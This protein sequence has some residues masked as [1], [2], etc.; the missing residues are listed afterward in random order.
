MGL[1]DDAEDLAAEATRKSGLDDRPIANPCVLAV[2]YL[3]LRLI[4]RRRG[5]PRL[6]PGRII[7][8]ADATEKARAFFVAHEAFHELIRR[9]RWRCSKDEEEIAASRGGCALQ[10]PRAP[11]LR[12]VRKEGVDL[13]RLCSLWTLTT[14]WVVARRI[15]ELQP[16]LAVR[17]RRGRGLDSVGHGDPRQLRLAL[18][19]AEHVGRAIG[20]GVCAVRIAPR[21]V[22]GV[23]LADVG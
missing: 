19:E 23:V 2:C 8:P 18:D 17:R 3:E 5:G 12:D 9:A 7:Y 14:P 21:E 16:A 13:D 6:E 1:L 20:P 10:L 4:P 15:A 22:V 11:F